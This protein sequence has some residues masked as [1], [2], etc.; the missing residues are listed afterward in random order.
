MEKYYLITNGNKEG[1]KL[2]IPYV[3]DNINEGVFINYTQTV[4]FQKIS[5]SDVYNDSEEYVSKKRL[6]KDKIILIGSTALGLHD[7]FYTPNGTMQ[8]VYLHANMINT[9]LN[10]NFITKVNIKNELLFLIVLTFFLV[11]FILKVN[12]KIYQMIIVM[13]MTIIMTA[14]EGLCFIWFGKLFNF[15][16]ELFTIIL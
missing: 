6:V 14:F 2:Y 9:I 5:F 1:K 10:E 15:P 3:S 7:E 11:I 12:N 16:I 8:G 4:N 13:I